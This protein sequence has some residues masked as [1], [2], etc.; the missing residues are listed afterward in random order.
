MFQSASEDL[1]IK[2]QGDLS[3]TQ[4]LDMIEANI[5]LSDAQNALQTSIRTASTFFN[6]TL[7]NFIG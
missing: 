5:K 2:L 6:Y 1:N 3:A 4:D 7:T